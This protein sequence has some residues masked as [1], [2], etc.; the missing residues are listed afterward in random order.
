M[1]E[2]RLERSGKTTVVTEQQVREDLRKGRLSG[3]EMVRPPGATG[4]LPLH[5]LALFAE[6]VPVRRD[7]RRAVDARTARGWA[8][9]LLVFLFVVV[10]AGQGT[11]PTWSFFW[12]IGLLAHTMRGLPATIRTL[13]T[14]GGGAPPVPERITSTAVPRPLHEAVPAAVPAE[15]SA[16]TPAPI[17]HSDFLQQVSGAVSAVK[18]VWSRG[19]QALGPA[20]DLAG[21]TT[22]AQ[23][24][25]ARHKALV[26]LHRHEDRATLEA[27]LSAA[28]A[29]ASGTEDAVTADIYGQEAA[30]IAERLAG[31]D[32]AIS[33]AEQ[34]AARKR[35][36]LHQLA[37]LRLAAG[38]TAA[39]HDG[40]EPAR[41]AGT[42]VEKTAT[43]RDALHASAEVDDALVRARK[44]AVAAR[45]TRHS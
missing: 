12:G 26:E 5:T 21:L 18:A 11:I 22:A 7:S 32:A 27:E 28:E 3:A 40:T 13:R 31:I 24:L 2:W 16:P 33:V 1:A 45:R 35:T 38:Q 34:L 23:Q 30:A 4:W 36:L 41:V 19:A 37:G 42:L 8:I 6:E 43:L 10:W 44:A 29:R 20:P 39:T 14:L 15:S 9:H 25:E 17:A